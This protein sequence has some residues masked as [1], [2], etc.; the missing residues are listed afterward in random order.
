MYHHSRQV[1]VREENRARNKS[2]GIGKII[3]SK[4]YEPWKQKQKTHRHKI[5]Q[6]QESMIIY[7]NIIKQCIGCKENILVLFYMLPYFS[8]L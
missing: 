7:Q 6:F 1:L 4:R 8:R 2:L 3:G 5:H